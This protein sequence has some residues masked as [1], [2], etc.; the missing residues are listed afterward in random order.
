VIERTLSHSMSHNVRVSMKTGTLMFDWYGDMIPLRLDTNGLYERFKTPEEKLSHRKR[1]ILH[2]L[3]LVEHIISVFFY[4]NDVA[5]EIRRWLMRPFGY[6]EHKKS[7][8]VYNVKLSSLM[9]VMPAA[10]FDDM[11]QQRRLSVVYNGCRVH[12]VQSKTDPISLWYVYKNE[13]HSQRIKPEWLQWSL[14]DLFLMT[15]CVS[16]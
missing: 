10:S 12:F 9:R 13:H 5:N 1:S 7:G 14:Y 15:D 3:W 6:R 4:N 2:R 11:I 8:C 16:H